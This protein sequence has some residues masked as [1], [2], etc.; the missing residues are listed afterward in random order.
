ML[1]AALAAADAAFPATLERL[2]SLVRIPSVSFP[3]FDPVQVEASAAASAAWLQAAGFP[4]VR[5][6]REAGAAPCVLAEDRRAGPAAPT[7]LLYAHHDVQPPLREALWRSPPFA[8]ELREG[9]LWGRGTADD[10]AGI[11]VHAAAAAAWNA[12]APHPPCNLLALIEGEEEV[13]SPRL[14]ELC[15]LHR[16][17]LRCDACVVADLANLDTGIPSLTASLRGHV[18]CEVELRALRAPVHS[19]VWGGLVGDPVRALAAMLGS[20]ADADGRVLVPG[21]CDGAQEPDPAELAA[22]RAAPCDR[23]RIAQQAGLLD[24]ATLP[25][26]PAE[27]YARLWRRPA[28][29]VCAL[30]GG[31]R[32]R[33]GNVVM[34]AAWA[35][36]GLRT[37][38]GMDGA[39]ALDLIEAWLRA[40]VPRGMELAIEKHGTGQPWTIG[41]EGPWHARLRRALALGYGREA[42]AIG[43]GASI[44]FVAGL[45]E[46]LGGPAMLLIGVEDPQC[47]AHSEN[48]SLEVGDLQRAIRSLVA[49]MGGA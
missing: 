38:P 20:L 21:V 41:A 15:R 24:A 47:G 44:P 32:G 23:A 25:D 13:G 17:E 7:I 4:R 45:Q 42:V 34:D 46:L 39:R 5:V 31:E 26:D 12:V 49:L 48:E 29:A 27:I 2:C 43:C 14:L 19:G 33:T 16:E 22:W 18:S 35:R 8:P 36:L 9:R 3:G 37:V 30:Q 28:L 11:A 6:L 40:R 10:K 1:A